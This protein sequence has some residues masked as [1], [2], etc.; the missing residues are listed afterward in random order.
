MIELFLEIELLILGILIIAISVI[1]FQNTFNFEYK[2]LLDNE[3]L[4]R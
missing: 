4:Q 1:P 2:R 3:I